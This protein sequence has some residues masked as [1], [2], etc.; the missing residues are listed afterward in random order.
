MKFPVSI[1]QAHTT[2]IDDS[3]I[4]HQPK[5]LLINSTNRYRRVKGSISDTLE[6]LSAH[7]HIFLHFRNICARGGGFKQFSLVNVQ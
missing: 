5:K 2:T 7:V 3:P 1:V 6:K 4:V